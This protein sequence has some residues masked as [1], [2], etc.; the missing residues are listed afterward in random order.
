MDITDSFFGIKN[1]N[2][3][4]IK[5]GNDIKYRWL[6]NGLGNY[7]LHCYDQNNVEKLICIIKEFDNK[8]YLE[9]ALIGNSIVTYGSNGKVIGSADNKK[10]VFKNNI[11]NDFIDIFTDPDKVVKDDDKIGILNFD[12]FGRPSLSDGSN[13]NEMK[14]ISDSVISHFIDTSNGYEFGL[15]RQVDYFSSALTSLSLGQKN[16]LVKGINNA[17]DFKIYSSYKDRLFEVFGLDNEQNLA[18]KDFVVAVIICEGHVSV[19]VVDL[20]N[21]SKIVNIDLS[22]YHEKLFV[23]AKRYIEYLNNEPLQ[24][25]ECCS[26]IMLSCIEELSKISN[27]S[28]INKELLKKIMINASKKFYSVN[29]KA[30]LFPLRVLYYPKMDSNITNLSQEMFNA[31]FSMYDKEI[32]SYF[33]GNCLDFEGIFNEFGNKFR[34]KPEDLIDKQELWLV[35]VFVKKMELA[36][37]SILKSIEK[38]NSFEKEKSE[39]KNEES[40]VILLTKIEYLDKVVDN[41]CCHIN[42]LKIMEKELKNK[43]LKIQQNSLDERILESIKQI[44]SSIDFLE[45]NERIKQL[46]A[47]QDNKQLFD[48][49]RKMFSELFMNDIMKKRYIG[50]KT[51]IIDYKINYQEK[52]KEKISKRNQSD[53]TNTFKTIKDKLLK[54]R[55][56]KSQPIS[57][58]QREKFRR[59]NL[60]K[61]SKSSPIL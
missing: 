26:I 59:Q 13:I 7:S 6:T 8:F 15:S 9:K 12:E 17:D 56:Q 31:I 61:R 46:K 43:D 27:F 39:K 21:N 38:I 14:G 29:N 45:K 41:L 54:E 57:F 47:K 51:N 35:D 16:L 34:Q 10:F 11:G 1:A 58:V 50:S 3:E 53:L 37:K 23:N 30:P 36:E 42:N 33:S 32:S 49:Y 18:G 40:E 2:R 20:K 19:S 52:L 48:Y 55:K 28:N 44:K 4:G 22:K 25:S 60:E 5:F 24:I